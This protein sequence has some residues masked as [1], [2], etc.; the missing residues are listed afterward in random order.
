MGF[1]QGICIMGEG[2]WYFDLKL[3]QNRLSILE[4]QKTES[5]MWHTC[6]IVLSEF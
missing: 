6:A 5:L 4:L 1:E 2:Q 3:I